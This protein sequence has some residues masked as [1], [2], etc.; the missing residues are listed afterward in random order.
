MRNP[1]GA[2]MGS[3]VEGGGAVWG[4]VV[5]VFAGWLGYGSG[6]MCG[7]EVCVW[8]LLLVLEMVWWHSWWEI[9]WEGH[10]FLDVGGRARILPRLWV[11]LLVPL[12]AIC[13]APG[14]FGMIVLVLYAGRCG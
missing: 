13:A 10:C 14:R 2:F 3:V 7:G 9:Y 5:I 12:R 6:L 4:L 1:F 11:L 8:E